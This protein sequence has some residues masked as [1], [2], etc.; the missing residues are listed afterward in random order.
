MSNTTND[1]L[2]DFNSREDYKHVTKEYLRQYK[3]QDDD[4]RREKLRVLLVRLYNDLKVCIDKGQQSDGAINDNSIEGILAIADTCIEEQN[5]HKKNPTAPHYLEEDLNTILKD[6][7]HKE[8]MEARVNAF[9]SLCTKYRR[10]KEF[11]TFR[12][13]VNSDYDEVNS[14]PIFTIMRAYY[15]IQVSAIDFDREKALG[16]WNNSI[17]KHYKRLPAFTQIYTETVVLTYELGK[18]K[19]NSKLLEAK[20]LL[21]DAIKMRKYAKFYSTRGRI[22][23]CEGQ[24]EEAIKEVRLAIDN[25]DNNREDYMTRINE[26]EALISRFL[27][28]LEGQDLRQQTNEIKDEMSKN[29]MEHIKVL[30]FFSAII[31]LI[32]STVN[33]SN[34]EMVDALPM[35]IGLSGMIIISFGSLN[36]MLARKNEGRTGKYADWALLV[37]GIVIFALA[38]VARI[39]FKWLQT[40]GLV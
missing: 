23:C 2:L 21:D 11:D 7:A 3:T 18:Q 14:D 13:L 39:L 8:Q 33:V 32:I 35:L 1:V 25:E 10:A 28:K 20:R 12:L 37:I 16:Y 29:K 31:A 40:K 34:K 19:D 27:L 4:T 24:Y 30:G 9:Y 36:M 15:Y 22:L 5:E 38:F 17:P 6:A 26:Y